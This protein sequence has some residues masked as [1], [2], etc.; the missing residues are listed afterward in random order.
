MKGKRVILS[1]FTVAL[2]CMLSSHMLYATEKEQ[3]PPAGSTLADQLELQ[4]SV[5]EQL[6]KL[7]SD[8]WDDRQKAKKKLLEL[9]TKNKFVLNFFLKEVKK[10]K[11][12]EIRLSSKEILFEYFKKNIYNPDKGNGFIGIQ[13]SPAGSVKIKNQL[14]FP[15]RV[16]FPIK[17]FPGAK[18]GLKANDLILQID[19]QK[20]TSDFGLNEFVAYITTKAPGEKVTLKL[21][22]NMKVISKEVTLAKRPE[23]QMETLPKKSAANLF[24]EWYKVLI[25]KE[26]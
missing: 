11:D 2:Q 6:K 12:P 16:V 19:D 15:I 17:G 26:R 22:S 4:N 25:R 8:A 24:K 5:N 14:Y 21:L 13:L 23:D 3:F 20:C 10:S 18:A 1:V 7:D 9:I